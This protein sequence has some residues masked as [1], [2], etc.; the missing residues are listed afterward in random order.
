MAVLLCLLIN[1]VHVLSTVHM[2]LGTLGIRLI[3][4]LSTDFSSTNQYTSFV[5]K[6]IVDCCIS[7]CCVHT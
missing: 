4:L 1:V 6:N 5:F 7:L 3:M 2:Y